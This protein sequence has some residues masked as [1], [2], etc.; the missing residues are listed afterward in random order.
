MEGGLVK[1][2]KAQMNVC[3]KE[4]KK[5]HS[6]RDVKGVLQYNRVRWDYLCLLEKKKIFGSRERIIFFS[7]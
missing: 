5:L 3:R 2:M 4:M 1:E 6:R 7:N